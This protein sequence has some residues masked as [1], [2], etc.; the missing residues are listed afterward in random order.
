MTVTGPEA[1]E[2]TGTDKVVLDDEIVVLYETAP[3]GLLLSTTGPG[4]LR[5]T[6]IAAF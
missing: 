1:D 3:A 2:L 6:R 4:S 5:V